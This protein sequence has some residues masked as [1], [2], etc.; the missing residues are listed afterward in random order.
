VL[1]SSD[2]G[3]TWSTSTG[4]EPP[5]TRGVSVPEPARSDLPGR[6]DEDRDG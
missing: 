2:G 6:Q 1:R 5:P 3:K 4:R